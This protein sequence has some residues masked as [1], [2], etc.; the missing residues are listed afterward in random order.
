DP[1]RGIGPYRP[2]GFTPSPVRGRHNRLTT[3]SASHAFT[4]TA[5]TRKVTMDEFGW[6]DV[7]PGK[8]TGLENKATI[9]RDGA[10]GGKDRIW[11][12]DGDTV[13]FR[14]SKSNPDTL[15]RHNDF[16]AKGDYKHIETQG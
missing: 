8:T 1:A 4:L 9:M 6:L 11:W 13:W 3:V 15:R 2:G 5:R 16:V 7:Q 12:T 10:F 14:R